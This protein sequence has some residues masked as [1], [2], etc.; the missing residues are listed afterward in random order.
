MRPEVYPHRRDCHQEDGSHDSA[1]PALNRHEEMVKLGLVYLCFLFGARCGWIAVPSL[2]TEEEEVPKEARHHHAE[3]RETMTARIRDF[4]ALFGSHQ[5]QAQA[6]MLTNIVVLQVRTVTPR[7][8]QTQMVR[9]P[10]A[11][12]RRAHQS[13]RSRAVIVARSVAFSKS[14]QL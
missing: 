11:A 7:D 10:T 4:A 12:M 5:K 6:A 1:S 2:T 9:P 3:H 14:V 8:Q 13:G